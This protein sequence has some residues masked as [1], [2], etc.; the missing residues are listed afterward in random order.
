MQQIISHGEMRSGCQS[1]C[2]SLSPLPR[3]LIPPYT[4]R[5]ISVCGDIAVAEESTC[6]PSVAVTL[7]LSV[8]IC[9]DRGNTHTAQAFITLSVPLQTFHGST[10]TQYIAE[11][12]VRLCRGPVCFT[13]PAQAN[14]CLDVC[15]RVYGVKQQ[16]VYTSSVCAPAC[17]Q[18]PLYPPPRCP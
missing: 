15:I 10:C 4:V 16:A 17:P 8:L 14:V 7:P 2:L 6:C 11:A 18:L 1:Y 5:S 9:D 3:I 12:D 13:D